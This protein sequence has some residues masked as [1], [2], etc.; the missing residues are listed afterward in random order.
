M[1]P[2]PDA[3]QITV[4]GQPRAIAPGATVADLIRELG[5]SKTACAAEINKQLVPRREQATRT[6]AESDTVELVTLVGGG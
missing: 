6:L 1:A 5:L 2:M 3:I 4:N